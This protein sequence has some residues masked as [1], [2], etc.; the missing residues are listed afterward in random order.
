MDY[1][2]ADLSGFVATVQLRFKSDIYPHW[3]VR[4][5]D[6]KILSLTITQKLI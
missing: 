4:S 3:F 5:L 6:Y 1:L 2:S